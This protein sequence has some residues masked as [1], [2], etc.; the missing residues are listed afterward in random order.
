MTDS[1]C[2]TVPS[3]MTVTP[4][5]VTSGGKSSHFFFP[6][7]TVFHAAVKLGSTWKLVPVRAGP[8]S[9]HLVLGEV[10]GGV[11]WVCD[12]VMVCVMVCVVMVC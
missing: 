3:G 7:M 9:S 4:G 11:G 5:G 2:R 1:G 8:R 10:E 12:D 6:R